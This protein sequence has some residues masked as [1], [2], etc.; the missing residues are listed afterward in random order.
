MKDKPVQEPTPASELEVL[1]AQVA[2]LTTLK[3]REFYGVRAWCGHTNHPAPA[4]L[5]GLIAEKLNWRG[6]AI[7]SR[8]RIAE[9]EAERDRLKTAFD[10]VRALSEGRTG[11]LRPPGW[12]LS[13]ADVREA[14]NEAMDALDQPAKE[15]Q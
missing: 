2:E 5:A 6:E 15:G 9:L 8:K 13:P 14:L 4:A 3:T 11:K 7:Q 10:K 1:R 12:V